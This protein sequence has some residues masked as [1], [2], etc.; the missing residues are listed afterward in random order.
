MKLSEST[1]ARLAS[2]HFSIR[3]SVSGISAARMN[4]HPAPGKW[5]IHDNMAHLARYNVVFQERLNTMMTEVAPRFSRYVAED[6]TEFPGWQQKSTGELIQSISAEREKIFALAKSFAENDLNRIGIHPRFGNLSIAGWLDFFLLHEAH[7]MF[8][9]F[10]L[11]N[12]VTI[13]A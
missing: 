2:Q 6:D 1:L 8:T 10:Q 3:E 11:K 4:Y 12:D 13:T 7:H 5:S 9:I